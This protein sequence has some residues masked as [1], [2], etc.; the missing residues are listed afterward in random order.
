[1]IVLKG[2]SMQ[3]AES[4]IWIQELPTP[5]GPTTLIMVAQGMVR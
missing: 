1:M 5:A 3:T 4:F 2:A